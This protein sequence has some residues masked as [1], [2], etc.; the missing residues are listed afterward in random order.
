[1]SS[2]RVEM[3]GDSLHPRKKPRRLGAARGGEES[4]VRRWALPMSSRASLLP[5]LL[6][7]MGGK[8][9]EKSDEKA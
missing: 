2:V 3:T 1:M 5:P 6:D 7:P 8:E 4:I 9:K